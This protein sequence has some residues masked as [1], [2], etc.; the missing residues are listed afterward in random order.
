MHG[1]QIMAL[2]KHTN[3]QDELIGSTE[4]IHIVDAGAG[5]G[6]TYSIVK[7]YG[8]ILDK[9]YKPENILLITFTKNAAEQMREKVVKDFSEKS[10]ISRLLEAPIMTFHAFCSRLLK[11]SGMNSPSYL[12][13]DEFISGNFSLAED[14]SF[15]EEMFRKFFM[16]FSGIN[17]EKYESIQYALEGKVNDVLSVIKKLCSVGIFPSAN[18]WSESDKEKLKGNYELFSERF[19]RMNE[20]RKGERGDKQSLL[21]EKFK[22]TV[23]DKLYK[24]FKEGDVYAVKNVNPGIKES[25]FND[26]AQELFHEF[27]ND[28]YLSY[29]EYM[30]KRNQLNYEFMV[31]FAYLVLYNNKNLRQ[32]NQF[33]Y[34]MIDEFQDTDELQFKIILLLCKNMNGIANLCAVGDWKQGIYSFRNTKIENITEFKNRL[35]EFAD[36]LNKDEKRIEFDTGDHTKIIFENNYRSSDTI[37]KFS[38]GTLFV[39]ATAEDEV[40]EDFVSSNFAEP[41]LPERKLEDL[42]EIKFYKAADRIDECRLVLKKISQL[43]NEKDKYKIRIF[44]NETGKVAEERPVMYSDIC[45]LSRNKKFCHELQREAM[46]AG[47]PVNYSGGIEIFASEQGVLILAWL[48]LLLNE[49]DISGWIPVLDK[50]GYSFPEVK[51]FSDNFIKENSVNSDLIPADLFEFLR[52][53]KTFRNNILFAVEAILGRYRYYD[54]TANKLIAVIQQWNSS[55]LISLNELVRIIENSANAEFDTESGNTSDAVL[56]QTIHASKGLEYP[57]VFI[58]NVNEKIFPDTKGDKGKIIFNHSA[59]LRAKTFYGTNG[60]YNYI[61]NNWKTDLI[62][63]VTKNP[64]YAEE[65][66]LLYV[67]VTRAKQYLYF[68]SH[69]PSPFFVQ[70]AGKSGSEIISDF[71][72][73]IIKNKT[74]EI[75][76]SEVTADE[77]DVDKGRKFISPHA[78]MENLID[79][80]ADTVTEENEYS[81]NLRNKN[82]EFGLMIHNIANKTANGIEVESDIEEVKRIKEFIHSLKAD[83]LIAEADFL[84][85]EENRTIRGTIDLLAFYK[86]RVTVIDYKTDKDKK[87]IEKYKL[88]IQI[89]K[90]SIKSIYKDKEAE[91]LIYFVSLDEMVIV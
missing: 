39:S 87:N 12:G 89:Y 80:S 84:Y 66:R 18:G 28:V 46:T 42:T 7:R 70:T 23:R 10:G 90:N 57:V 73:E 15:E 62:N 74:E 77:S 27:I 64:D 29:I 63:A 47:I 79:E 36:E 44:E 43:I 20:I 21:S 2:K 8:N 37:L 34:V 91:G 88:Q 13:L 55:E 24:D 61:F 40:D 71:E 53:L 86:D 75:S 19:D 3:P 78:L 65:R 52:H 38:R 48:R 17:N 85:P 16:T 30:L 26:E 11:K 4:G 45:V 76:V 67:A 22:N 1:K 72:Y 51:Y 59:G 14:S 54:E 82:R 56:T 58:A 5:T 33:E 31:M 25:I 60:S 9:S 69:R 32:N 68:T 49:K 50:E 41:L 83:K 6:K 81:I 35:S